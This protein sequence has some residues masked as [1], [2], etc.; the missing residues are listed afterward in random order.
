MELGRKNEITM[1]RSP[2]CMK[3]T[4]YP[5]SISELILI[6]GRPQTRNLTTAQRPYFD[7]KEQAFYHNAINSNK[8][9]SSGS[10]SGTAYRRTLGAVY[11]KPGKEF[12]KFTH[13]YDQRRKRSQLF[14]SFGDS[15]GGPLGIVMDMPGIK[16]E[17]AQIIAFSASCPRRRLLNTPNAFTAF[18]CHMEL[19]P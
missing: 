18:R 4:S 14:F 9:V 2:V 5:D 3:V 17:G 15:L 11:T 1:S 8:V 19:D 16:S 7:S 10:A 12:G 6:M 13:P